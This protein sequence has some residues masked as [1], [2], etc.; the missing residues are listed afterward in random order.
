MCGIVI[1]IYFPMFTNISPINIFILIL[2]E[3]YIYMY[4]FCAYMEKYVFIGLLKI[5]CH[6]NA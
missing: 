1:L 6:A 5:P 4:R 3:S 2:M